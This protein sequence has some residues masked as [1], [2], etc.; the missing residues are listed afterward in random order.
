MTKE[1]FYSVGYKIFPSCLNDEDVRDCIVA[2]NTWTQKFSQMGYVF[3]QDVY[4]DPAFVRVSKTPFLLDQLRVFTGG[5]PE[6]Y[7]SAAVIA[8]PEL[9]PPRAT[10][11]HIDK[12]SPDGSGV[13]VVFYFTDVSREN[14]GNTYIKPGSHGIKD[15]P[16]LPVMQVTC[17]A[18]SVIMYRTDLWH[19]P[20]VNT[21]KV[22]RKALF[23]SYKKTDV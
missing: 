7:N 5:E 8:Y 3:I 4:S 23:L 16:D 2:I 11:W 17:P 12:N 19:S 1:E 6:V 21:S 20:S 22:T 18:G 15:N 13:K 9:K 10:V 14:C